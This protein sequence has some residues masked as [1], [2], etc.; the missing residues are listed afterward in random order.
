MIA[1]DMTGGVAIILGHTGKN[2]G[3]GMSGGLAF[4]YDPDHRLPSKC[5]PDVAKDLSP[6]AAGGVTPHLS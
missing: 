4:V 2:F 5:N 3:A 1:A 6:L